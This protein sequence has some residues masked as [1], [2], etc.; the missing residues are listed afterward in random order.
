MG[1]IRRLLEPLVRPA[2]FASEGAPLA[3]AAS[4]A[5]GALLL[6]TVVVQAQ[7]PCAGRKL[8]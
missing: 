6:C 8:G 1:R 7:R 2:E 3:R 4:V 5:G